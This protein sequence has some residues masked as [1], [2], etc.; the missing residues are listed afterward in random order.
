VKIEV[1][2]YDVTEYWHKSHLTMIGRR[3]PDKR[4]AMSVRP[5]LEI[6]N[7]FF[8]QTNER[9]L[10]VTGSPRAREEQRLA[11]EPRRKRLLR[12]LRSLGRG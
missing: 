7:V 1:T 10:P 2:Y 6:A 4:G 5:E 9:L 8:S 3:P 11:S 12:W